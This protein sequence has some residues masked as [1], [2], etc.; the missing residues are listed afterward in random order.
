MLSL[1]QRKYWDSFI[2]V[3]IIASAVE[4]PFS[5]FVG[6]TN[7]PLGETISLAFLFLFTIDIV[8]NLFTYQARRYSGLFNWRSLAGVFMPKL[9]PEEFKRRFYTNF[10]ASKTL[11][12]VLKADGLIT[13]AQLSEAL[14]AQTADA[15]PLGKTLIRLGYITPEEIE[16]AVVKVEKDPTELLG[17]KASMISYT[18]SIW[19]FIDFVAVIPFEYIAANF[20]ALEMIKMLRLFRLV[21]LMKMFQLLHRLNE[22]FSLNPSL[23]RFVKISF[24][25]P[26]IIFLNAT[27]LFYIENGNHE[28]ITQFTDA[29]N[30]S[31]ALYWSV[32]KASLPYT[33]N[34]GFVLNLVNAIIAYFVFGIFMGNFATLFN[35]TDAMD[36][37]FEKKKSEWEE[38]FK[39]YPEVF[40]K[41]EKV[42]VLRQIKKRLFYAKQIKVDNHLTLIK[43]LDY[44][45]EKHIL[46]NFKE[47]YPD[48]PITKRIKKDFD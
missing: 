46:D 43:S 39:L 10:K 47:H 27:I 26:Y 14:E 29:L 9:S 42:S 4:I 16:N 8:L 38:L 11:G 7:E 23:R 17:K 30:A 21:R 34:P 20:A 31:F 45:L 35:K 32:G 2:A 1:E 48:K 5:L 33:G 41:S 44:N 3:V 37:E 13:D 6:Y 36:K 24:M 15:A 19:F 25:V 28:K 18:T 40:T 22:F 12:E